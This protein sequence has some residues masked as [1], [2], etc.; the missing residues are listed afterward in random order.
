M[1]NSESKAVGELGKIA[2]S[3]ANESGGIVPRRNASVDEA[4]KASLESPGLDGVEL[5]VDALEQESKFSP[6]Y[7]QDKELQERG[8]LFGPPD[9]DHAPLEDE[10]AN[11][12]K[13]NKQTKAMTKPM[14]MVV[15][16]KRKNKKNDENP[17]SPVFSSQQQEE[18]SVS[19]PKKMN[20]KKS[21]ACEVAG[22]RSSSPR[23]Q[24]KQV[25]YRD[26]SGK[27]CYT[28]SLQ[29][30]WFPRTARPAMPMACATKMWDGIQNMIRED[31]KEYLASATTTTRSCA[32]A[33]HRMNLNKKSRYVLREAWEMFGAQYLRRMEILDKEKLLGTQTSLLIDPDLRPG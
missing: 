26:E 12:K 9:D 14:K 8:V 3:M 33:Y 18:S 24:E 25:T 13:E 32:T 17:P 6:V 10:D 7:C 29:D 22:K 20:K 16:M 28:S 1:K 2:N 15:A 4:A 31:Q 5:D 27:L 19:P 23:K 11:N 21:A 30:K